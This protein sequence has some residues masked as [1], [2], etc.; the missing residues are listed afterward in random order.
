MKFDRQSYA[1]SDQL[2]QVGGDAFVLS[3]LGN[4]LERNPVGIDTHT[5]VSGPRYIGF[6]LRRE[7]DGWNAGI[8][9]PDSEAKTSQSTRKK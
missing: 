1:L 9:R 5:N 2:H 4:A 7:F 6:F 8:C 3:L